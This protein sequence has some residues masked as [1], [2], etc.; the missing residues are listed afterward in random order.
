M[1]AH[2]RASDQ[3]DAPVRSEKAQPARCLAVT[4]LRALRQ[5]TAFVDHGTAYVAAG[6]DDGTREDH[7]V[8]DPTAVLN[9]DVR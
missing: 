9:A 7:A 6:T 2:H 1:E 3:G 8:L 5:Y 4:D